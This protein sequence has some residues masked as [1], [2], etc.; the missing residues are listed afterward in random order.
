MEE[1]VVHLAAFGAKPGALLRRLAK[2]E[3]AAITIIEKDPVGDAAL[4]TDVE[5]DRLINR[6]FAFDVTR[7]VGIPVDERAAAFVETRSFFSEAVEVLVK[8][9]FLC[10]SDERAGFRVKH[11]S[12]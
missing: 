8:A 3:V 1:V 12:G 4:Q 6:I 10:S 11:Y 2:I 5:R 7:C 9:E